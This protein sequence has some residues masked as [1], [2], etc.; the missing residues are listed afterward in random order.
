MS[1]VLGRPTLSNG[2]MAPEEQGSEHHKETACAFTHVLVIL[3]YRMSRSLAAQGLHRQR[4][5]GMQEQLFASF[6]QGDERAFRVERTLVDVEDL[7]HGAD[8]GRVF[9]RRNA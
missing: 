5:T 1:K 9:F 3:A 7:F 6:I 8:K 2:D 4:L